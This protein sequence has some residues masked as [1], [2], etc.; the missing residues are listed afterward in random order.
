MRVCY[1]EVVTQSWGFTMIETLVAAALLTVTLGAALI[2]T[3]TA[4]QLVGD[5]QLRSQA[6]SLAR[7]RLERAHNVAYADL[8][9]VG[10]I[11]AGSLPAE[12][13]ITLNSLPF[14]I[15]TSVVFVDD[16]FDSTAPLDVIPAD[17][18]RVR[19][20]VTWEGVFASR[21]KPVVLWTDIAPRGV[22][23]LE[24]SGTLSIQVLNAGGERVSGAQVRIVADSVNPAIDTTSITDAFGQVLLPGA[25]ECAACYQITVT[26]SGYTTDRTYGVNE[27]A[28]PEKPHVSIIEGQVSE[29]SFLI[30]VPATVTFKAVRG[31]GQNYAP[32]SG[33][34]MRVRGTKEI[35]RTTL[36]EPVYLY[37]QDVVAVGP[38]AQVTVN[39]MVWDT[40]N[41][42]IPPGST[43]DF[44]GSTPFTPFNITPGSSTVFTMVVEPASDHNLLITIMDSTSQRLASATAELINLGTGLV[45]TKSAGLLGSPDWSQIFFPNL[46]LN[47]Y[48]LKVWSTGYQEATAS[49]QIN[50]DMS[51]QFLLSP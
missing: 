16:P 7:D 28:N 45:A 12:E 1:A 13:S 26:K 49:V 5:V 30:D 19:V 2:I 39:D 32:F 43:V 23:T 37:S 22:E 33:V 24:D 36:D 34:Q 14:T 31:A 41:V 40:Y 8:G 48:S 21:N 20:E 35:G 3:Q 44:A 4:V 50:G 18:K 42:S 10:G 27:V 29:A 11:P 9:T 47:H 25:P 51:E 46:N 15:R 17:Y 6:S 38:Q